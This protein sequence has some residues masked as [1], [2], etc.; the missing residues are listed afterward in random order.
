MTRPAVYVFVI[1][2]CAAAFWFSQQ[3]KPQPSP[4]APAVAEKVVSPRLKEVPSGEISP[5]IEKTP[6]EPDTSV[7][8]PD[9][10]LAHDGSERIFAIIANPNLDFPLAVIRMLEILPQLNETDQAEAAQHIANLSEEKSVE[11]WTA[12]LVSNRLPLPA[13]EVLFNDLLN[14]PHVSTMPALASIAD[15]TTHPK[16]KSS[17][18]ILDSLYGQPPQGMSWAAW[19]KAKMA[20]QPR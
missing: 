3:T 9:P 18:E 5:R 4:R 16:S 13:A 15:Q 19:V 12:L 2:M 7:H 6:S 20:E 10:A 14:R 1:V 17:I 11:Q 8:L